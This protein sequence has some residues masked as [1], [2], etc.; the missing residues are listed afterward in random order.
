MLLTLLR[1]LAFDHF[2]K[3]KNIMNNSG[4]IITALVIG[5]AVGAVLGVLFAPG[6]GSE[7]RRKI[8]EEGKRMSDAL[9]NKYNEMKEKTNAVKDD[10]E[11][12]A[13][14]FA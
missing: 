1:P 3:N 4:K 9:K 12:Q 14:D 7:T 8:N 2:L 11:Q 5:A 6:S 13:E 10:M